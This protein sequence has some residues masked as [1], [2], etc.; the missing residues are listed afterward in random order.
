MSSGHN[1][2]L[3]AHSLAQETIAKYTQSD[4]LYV[5]ITTLKQVIRRYAL[6]LVKLRWHSYQNHLEMSLSLNSRYQNIVLALGN[7]QYSL[8]GN[9]QY[10]G[11]FPDPYQSAGFTH[12]IL[13]QHPDPRTILLIGGGITGIIYEMLK[14]PVQ[15]IHYV[16]LDPT[17][18][19]ATYS[20]LSTQNK[21]ALNDERVQLFYTDGRHFVKTTSDTYD[22]I[23][24]NVPDPSTANLNRFYTLDFFKQVQGKLNDGGV[25]VTRISSSLNY[26]ASEVGMYTSSLY[27]TLKILFPFIVITP[28]TKNYFFATSMPDVIT[29]ESEV[30]TQRIIKRNIHSDF[31]TP[32]QFAA[33]YPEERVESLKSALEEK[34]TNQINTDSFPITYF[35]NL[36]LWDIISGERGK[37]TFLQYIGLILRWAVISLFLLFLLRIVYVLARKDRL[38]DHLKFNGLL[39]IATTG[40]TGMAIEVILLFAYQNIYGY[41]YY[42]IGLI[43]ALF[44]LGLSLGGW[45]MTRIIAGRARNWVKILAA[46]EFTLVLYCLSLPYILATFSA[47]DSHNLNYEYLF[48]FLVIGAGWLTGL[49]FPLVSKIL[50]KRDEIGSVAGWVDSFDHL[51]ACCGALLTGTI[52]VPLLGTHQSCIIAALFNG[53]S[54]LLLLTYLL[55]KGKQTN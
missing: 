11:S 9:G 42:K 10:I 31:F 6:V 48:M 17:L 19:A 4:H 13:S 27:Q 23:I 12:S 50:I 53:M 39:A 47:Q 51:G 40:F 38:L 49:Q 46:L 30:L 15:L 41:L 8:F 35:Y 28:G 32:F 45:L 7:E 33:L 16:E 52:L 25:L 55:Q 20:F 3:S 43:V 24:L 44:M 5:E 1:I 29:S 18:V 34:P 26:L 21:T 2:N 22:M 36:I 54:G 14:H 37:E